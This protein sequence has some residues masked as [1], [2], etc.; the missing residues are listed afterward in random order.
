ME[1]LAVYKAVKTPG[2]CL[3]AV[4]DDTDGGRLLIGGKDICQR[5]SGRCS[6]CP[7]ISHL[8]FLLKTGVIDQDTRIWRISLNWRLFLPN[9]S[10]ADLPPLFAYRARHK[11]LLPTA[12]GASQFRQVIG[13]EKPPLHDPPSACRIFRRSSS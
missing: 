3:N 7:H 6:A 9:S 5:L 10:S 13:T 8:F 4:V 1:L 11:P 2:F 12:T